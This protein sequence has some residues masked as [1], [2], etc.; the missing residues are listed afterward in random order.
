MLMLRVASTPTLP[1]EVGVTGSS[2]SVDLSES[3]AQTTSA[4]T[5]D[6]LPNASVEAARRALLDTIGVSVAA[7]NAGV[8]DIAPIRAW[9]SASESP[10][11]LPALGTSTRLSLND[12]A[13]WC[14]ALSHALDFDDYAD[15]VHPSAPVVCAALTLAQSLPDVD[16]RDLLLAIATGQDLIIRLALALDRSLGDHGWLPSLPG[17]LGAALTSARLMGLSVEG[18]RSAL[19]IALHQT[20][21]TMQA[22][23]GVGSGYRGIREGFNTYG[24]IMAAQLA[25]HGLRGDPE[26][27]EGPHGLFNQFFGGSY[28]RERFLAGLGSDL[29][30]P[31]IT[32]KRW[33]SAGHTHLFLTGVADLCQGRRYRPDEVRRVS[34]AG[35]SALLRIQC[36]PQ[37]LRIAPPHAI[38]A[39]ISIPFLVGKML[40]N[41]TVRLADFLDDGLADEPAIELARRVDWSCDPDRFPRVA[42]GFGAAEVE[43]ELE[44][45]EVLRTR[46]E[47]PLGHPSRPLS[48]D[49]LAAK[50]DDCIAFGAGDFDTDTLKSAVA[51][52]A[53]LE[54]HGELDKLLV[55]L[56]LRP[57]Q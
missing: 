6:A 17:T 25:G 5:Y 22:L 36:E 46:I 53:R 13:F 28:D 32:F 51:T 8:A 12:A 23:D 21:G 44:T 43:I 41:G 54:R 1:C 24:G 29:L 30:G 26:S 57:R 4:L 9:I 47:N 3:I 15:I 27:F 39:K 7:T 16:G 14:G 11:G 55:Q 20:S 48:W 56:G 18:I 2:N 38:D 49:E 50:Y 35:G 34:L 42:E 33:P 52:I 10:T 40:V 37:E 31:R 45:G 19:G